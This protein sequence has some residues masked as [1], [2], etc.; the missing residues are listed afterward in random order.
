MA[1]NVKKQWFDS[2]EFAGQ[3]HTELP[4]GAFCAKEETLFR[5]WAPT[6]SQVILRLY[7]AGN[8]CEALQQLPMTRGEKGT[9]EMRM[10]E[11]L[12][13]YYYDYAVTVDQ[14]TYETGDPYA[15]SCGVNGRRSMVLDLPR[16][17]PAGWEQDKAP[18]AA[19]EQVIY[20][21]HIKD[22]SWDQAGGFAADD[23][24][25]F[26]ALTRHGTTLGGDGVH[27]TG[28]D[29]IKSL[30]VTHIQLM[31]IYDYGSVDERTPESGYNWGYDPVNY[32][33][34]EGSYSSDPYHGE[35]RVKELKEMIAALHANGFRVIMD[36]V[37]NHTYDLNVPLFKSA[38]WYYYR[39]KEDGTPANG[40]GCGNDVATERS[41]VSRYILESVLYWV[42]EYHIDGFRFDLMGLM[43][44]PLMN[45]IQEELDKRYGVG[46]KLIYGEPWRADNT[47]ACPG[48]V[49]ADKGNLKRLNINLGAFNDDVRDAVKGKIMDI[50]AVGFVNGGAISAQE[51]RNCVIGWAG[52]GFANQAP[53]QNIT[54]L[55]CH[56]DWTLWD[57]LVYTMDPGKNFTGSAEEILRANRMGAAINFF[58]QGRPF[59]LAGEEFGR[60]K[61][62]IKNSYCSAAD[63]NQ[64]DWT[65]AWENRELVD[66]YRGLIA[67]RKQLPGL[68]DKSVE[69]S[70]R[71]LETMQVSSKCAWVTLENGGEVW[72]RLLLI[73][74][75]EREAVTVQLPAGTWQVL[76]DDRSSFRWQEE[77]LVQERCAIAPV[78]T[79]ILGKLR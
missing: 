46:E 48:T 71:I 74:S 26:S 56:D 39:R 12:H 64:L 4:L 60:T 61:G 76:V 2:A 79:L 13:G 65:R 43:D 55:S 19:A 27:A 47:A 77:T 21:L 8:D 50:E 52:E 11:D 6:A 59:F 75:A 37:Y 49:L 23:R 36:V 35:V 66:Y 63:I 62:G 41:M 18:A 72:D 54:Y 30:G 15:K 73:T 44:V 17:D 24:G 42:S 58:C 67:L 57:K 29:Y 16:T 28:L 53:S 70:S 69:A 25:R 68:Q 20:E 40:S 78:S 34:P 9:W 22:F 1:R 45:R 32:N 3:F 14:T 5:L 51:L 7:P 33:I 10:P 38:P 31:P